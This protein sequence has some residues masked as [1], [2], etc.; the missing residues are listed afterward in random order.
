MNNLKNEKEPRNNFYLVDI[1][2][3]HFDTVKYLKKSWIFKSPKE[4]EPWKKLSLDY[5]GR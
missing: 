4:Y 1:S 3:E 2:T 5:G